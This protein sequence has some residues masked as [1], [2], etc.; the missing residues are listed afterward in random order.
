MAAGVLSVYELINESMFV[1][2][3]KSTDNDWETDVP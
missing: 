2:T 3:G 1:V